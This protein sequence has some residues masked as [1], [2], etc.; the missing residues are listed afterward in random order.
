MDSTWKATR[1]I[2]ILF[3]TFFL[4]KL[5]ERQK[6]VAIPNALESEMDMLCQM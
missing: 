6:S 2:S 4:Y 5:L 1:R 3:A